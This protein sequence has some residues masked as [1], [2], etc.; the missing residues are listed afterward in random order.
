MDALLVRAQMGLM[1]A[2]DATREW[3]SKLKMGATVRAECTQPRNA[4]F[5][6]KMFALFQYAYEYWSDMAPRL[7]YKGVE[8]QPDFDRFRRDITILAGFHHAVVNLKG[9][10]RFEADSL[11]YGSMSP[12]SFEK[13]YSQVIQVLLTRVFIAKQW[14]EDKLREIV[15]QICEFA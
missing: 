10:V 1:P 8:V 6:R 15:E 5:H 12:E 14:D 13:L 4:Q 11:S 7:T 3:F 2:D 9:E